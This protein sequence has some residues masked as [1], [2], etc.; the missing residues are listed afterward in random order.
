MNLFWIRGIKWDR[1]L[2]GAAGS[3]PGAVGFVRTDEQHPERRLAAD[4]CTFSQTG[5][6]VPPE[7]HETP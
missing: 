2:S 3:P 5:I 7:P 6:S 1:A 4:S